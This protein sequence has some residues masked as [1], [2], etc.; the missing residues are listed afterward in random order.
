MTEF[1]AIL[2]VLAML[3]F[4]LRRKPTKRTTYERGSKDVSSRTIST[5][6]RNHFGPV[7]RERWRFHEP[8]DDES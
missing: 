6:T 3:G 4:I 1:L 8:D 2:G 5:P 7:K